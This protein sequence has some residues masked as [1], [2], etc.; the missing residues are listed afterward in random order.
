MMEHMKNTSELCAATS[1]FQDEC[2]QSVVPPDLPP[3]RSLLRLNKARAVV[4]CRLHGSST[5]LSAFNSLLRSVLPG[6]ARTGL[7]PAPALFDSISQVL[8]LIIAFGMK[9]VRMLPRPKRSVKRQFLKFRFGILHN[10]AAGG[11]VRELFAVNLFWV[12]IS[13]LTAR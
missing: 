12:F 10:G 4:T 13:S 6:D 1:I 7:S 5:D 8:F 3:K 9:L 11:H 2:R